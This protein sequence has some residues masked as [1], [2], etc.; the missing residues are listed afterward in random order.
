MPKKIDNSGK[1]DKNRSLEEPTLTEALEQFN[2]ASKIEGKAQ[3][4]LQ[5]YDYVL[6]KFR[7]SLE[8]DDPHIS[9][10]SP[11]DVRSYLKNLI[12]Q[13]YAKATIAIHFR[14]LRALF[15][16][17]F[18]EGLLDESPPTKNI[19]E[20]K[21][22]KIYPKTLTEEEVE[23]MLSVVKENSQKWTGYRNYTI[24]LTFFE[25]GLRLSELINA[26]IDNLKLYK[27]SLQVTGK[28]SKEL[29]V[30]W[31]PTLN[32]QLRK[33][34][35]KRDQLDEIYE[36]TIFIAKTGE[37]LTPRNIQRT[38]TRIQGWAGLEDKKVS[39]HVLRHTSATM[40]AKNG[41]NTFQLQRFYGWENLKTARKYVHLSGRDL[42]EAMTEASP[43]ENMQNN[44]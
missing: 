15:N 37:K 43:I 28:G 22:P 11:E 10:I 25:L 41:M 14:V 9:S 20:P 21:T 35:R 4:T 44:V 2:Y 34:L 24:L 40:A 39:P 1:K 33:W 18:E 7:K 23:L 16:W 19:N 42:Q 13:D 31:G 8:M 27:N 12:D 32:K 30:T 36:D 17:L 26:E 5:Q 38:I 6:N 29:I 3:K